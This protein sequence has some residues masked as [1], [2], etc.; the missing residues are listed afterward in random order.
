MIYLRSIV[1]AGLLAGFAAEATAQFAAALPKPL[2]TKA[3]GARAQN[4]AQEDP[5]PDVPNLLVPQL[6]TGFSNDRAFVVGTLFTG[7]GKVKIAGVDRGFN[8]DLNAAKV[9]SSS[10]EAD[11]VK[12]DAIRDTKS[13]LTLLVENSGEVGLRV[14][15]CRNGCGFTTED[16]NKSYVGKLMFGAS[17]GS[18]TVPDK[19]DETQLAYGPVAQYYGAWR[20]TNGTDAK[21]I[22]HLVIGARTG[23][24]GVSNGSIPNVPDSHIIR[25]VSGTAALV[26]NG[27]VMFGLT[28]TQT[29]ASVKSYLPSLQITTTASVK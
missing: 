17:A 2:V 27:T 9:V 28:L 29:Q 5:T 20:L 25:Y 11:P 4:F 23:L 24:I 14:Y 8:L 3:A 10:D 1:V 22:G 6:G 26:A 19:S 16:A 21:G 13:V 7:M 18:F 15:G 12:R